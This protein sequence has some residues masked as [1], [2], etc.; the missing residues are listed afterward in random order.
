MSIMDDYTGNFSIHDVRKDRWGYVL[1][2][3]G[4][5]RAG[6]D[7]SGMTPYAYNIGD[8]NI[9]GDYKWNVWDDNW[10]QT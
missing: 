9:S 3:D 4:R 1:S 10:S 5:R 8:N 7:L 2:E 6:I